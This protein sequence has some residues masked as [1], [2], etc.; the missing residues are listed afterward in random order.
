MS[1]RIPNPYHELLSSIRHFPQYQWAGP[2]SAYL[3]GYLRWQREVRRAD[4]VAIP[5]PER[6]TV[7]LLSFRRVRNMEPIV[8]ALLRCEFVEKV[9]VSNNNP[10]IRMADWIRLRDD[11]LR[12]IDQPRKTP[13][14]IRFEL[15][16]KEPGR[17]FL[18][19]D[20][21][22]LL[23]PEQV[24]R[25]FLGVLSRPGAPHG[26]HGEGYVG[27]SK[28]TFPPY[29]RVDRK[30]YH[31]QVDNLNTVYGFTREHLAE[32]ERLAGRLDLGGGG[33]AEMGNGEDLL[34]SASGDE[35]PWIHDVGPVALCLS[36]HRI[37]VATW[38]SRPGFFTERKELFLKLRSLRPDLGVPGEESETVA[39]PLGSPAASA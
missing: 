6:L 32:M 37:G 39:A 31:G 12:L 3:Y 38:A 18:S 5:G 23:S 24:K 36:S 2:R 9:L 35:R 19:I 26:I 4:R 27:E 33:I 30:G 17:Y 21:D 15:A 14:G 22:V 8:G 25:L 28:K 10:E 16:R 34:V 20:D 1:Y 7:I 13:P 29:W 11:R